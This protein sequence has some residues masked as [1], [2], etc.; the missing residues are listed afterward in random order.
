MSQTSP[1]ATKAVIPA[2]G[3]A[4]RFL[5][6]TKAVPKELLPIV[7][8]PVLQYIV[9]EAAAAKLD[10]VTLVT[11]P[12]KDAMVDYFDA[13][14]DLD[15]ALKA[16]GKDAMLAAVKAP[17]EIAEIT[18]IRQGGAKG[19]GHAVGRA[20]AHVGSESFAVLLGDEFYPVEDK[21]LPRM[22]DLQ[23]ETGGIVLALLEV[24]REDVTRYGVA[25]VSPT[26][27]EDIVEVTGLVEKP[28]VEDAPSNLILIGRYVLPGSIFPV[29][30]ETGPGRGG[31]IQ[32]TD[33]MDTMRANGTP[34]HGVVFRGR[35]YDTG[36][37]AAYLQTLVE[38]ASERDDLPGFNAWLR[39]FSARL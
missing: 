34:V 29:I 35:R 8:K 39:E 26:D 5:P 19:L 30:A 9:E 18:A 3:F 7:D 25:A 36:E 20:S 17:E 14:A 10:D 28:D 1:R 16:K 22:I 33:A 4:T 37:P 13:R 2:A 27:V 15:N 23:A 12:G 32:L 24:P 11:A 21:L 38:L 6:V 31:E